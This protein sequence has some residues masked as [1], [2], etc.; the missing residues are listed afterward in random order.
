MSV[1]AICAAAQLIFLFGR[2]R[3]AVYIAS[4]G[5]GPVGCISYNM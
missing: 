1:D 3:L 2:T 5:A 4:L